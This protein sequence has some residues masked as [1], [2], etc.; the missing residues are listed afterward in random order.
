M[1]RVG[2]D[3]GG[4]FTDLYATDED[5]PDAASAI[6]TAKVLSTPHD[7]S[8]GV[9]SALSV[10]GIAPAD[11]SVFVHGTTIATNALIERKY[12]EPALITTSGFRDVLEIGRQRRK[13]LYDPYQVKPRPLIRR[14]NRFTVTE[15][16]GSDGTTVTPLD[17][18]E[19][20]GLVRGIRDNGTHNLAIAF[21]NSYQNGAH[22]QRAREIVLEEIPDA[23]VALSSET[24]PKV[25]EL[26][27]FVT[28]AI[29]A[30]MLPVV[31]DYMTRLE[32]QLAEQ[33]CTAPLYIMKSNGGMM[34]SHTAKER[35]EE[36]IE[37]GPAGGVAAGAHLSSL[38]GGRNLIV[39]DVG[40]TSFEAALLE[41]G[42]G[43]VTDEY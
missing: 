18:D 24:R 2:V 4:T 41:D 8:E 9:L 23:M 40:G 36:L 16:M 39:T 30:A 29:R 33:G 34:S 43:L 1:F 27:R 20:R 10:A 38:L 25:R 31:G 26:G 22:E 5:A 6:R 37:S 11:I 19:L 32:S 12:A 17:E 3:I 14:A 13:A 42:R 28:T 15:K 7:P 35:P 21:I